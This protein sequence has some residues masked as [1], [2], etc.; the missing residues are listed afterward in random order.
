MTARPTSSHSN[1]SR[2]NGVEFAG[3]DAELIARMEKAL[4]PGSAITQEEIGR[5]A[6]PPDALS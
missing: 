2:I 5:P 4:E 3:R 1:L 6:L